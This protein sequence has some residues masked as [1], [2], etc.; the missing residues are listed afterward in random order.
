[1]STQ[2]AVDL[3][4]KTQ[5]LGKLKGLT[6]ET[7]KFQ[8]AAKKAQGSS[9]KLGR[10]LG[11]VGAKAGQA[12]N[13]ITKTGRAAKGAAKSIGGLRSALL[14][15][16]VGFAV[17]KAFGDASALES[18]ET[19]INSLTKAY[20]K[21]DGVQA[22]AAKSAEKFRLTQTEAL[23]AYADLGSRLGGTNTSLADLANI[24]DGFNTLL[25]N[26]KVEAQ[27]AAAA[28]LQLGQALGEGVLRAEE[29][30]SLIATTPQLLDEV[31]RVMKVP[32]AGLKA[33]AGEGKISSEALIQALANIK[34]KGADQ[35]E[36]S[37][38]GA[39]GTSKD[40]NKALSEFSVVIGT[41]LLPAIVPLLQ[42]ATELLKAFG[43]LPAPIKTASVAIAGTAVAA[44]LLAPAF[45]TAAAA[46]KGLVGVSAALIAAL[47]TQTALMVAFGPKIYAT[48]AAKGVL[49]AATGVLTKALGLLKVA[50][51][52]LPWAAFIAAAVAAANATYQ[53][54]AA[55]VDF[56]R[57]L[58]EAPLSEVEKKIEEL[59]KDLITAE[60]KTVAWYESLLDFIIGA[61]GASTAVD[62]LS[63]SI[64]RLNQRKIQLTDLRP[65]QGA[66]LDMDQIK[67]LSQTYEAPK[68][69]APKITAPSGGG[70]RGAA[71]RESEIP[72]LTRQI[73]LSD[74][75]LLIDKDRLEA[76]FQGNTQEIQR[77]ENLRVRTELEGKI[78]DIEAEKIPQAEQKLKI[79]LAENEAAL[80]G[81]DLKYAGLEADKQR[82]EA[83]EG[84]LTGFDREIELSNTK[85]DLAKG[86]LGIEHDII[87]MRKSGLLVGDE[88]IQQYR[89]RAKAALEASGAGKGKIQKKIEEYQEQLA[90]T[91]GMIVSLAGTVE[92][93]IGS[94]MSN[95][96]TGLIDGTTTAQ[97]AFSSMF[98][99]IGKAFID[100]ATQMIAKALI[101][102]ALGIL[103]G[104]GSSGGG[105]GSF[106]GGAPL[107]DLS[108]SMPWSSWAGGGYT[109]DGARSGGV[110]GQGGFPAILHPQET[111]IDHSASSAALARYS[112]NNHASSGAGGASG[113][114]EGTGG[115]G[116]F[117]PVINVS[118]GPTMQ[119]EG[120]NHVSQSDFQAGLAQAAKQGGE[121]G[122]QRALRK[123]RSS[124]A[125]R[126]RIG[127]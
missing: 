22:I 7:N 2:Y 77:L 95:A 114:S 37:L 78:A 38:A 107:G 48:A 46:I 127:M 33:L 84:M 13:G 11:G 92:S 120:S 50:M 45:G 4:L 56:N 113:E 47:K 99:N 104:G 3:V 102:K 28:Q 108:G 57:V 19:R 101:M 88:E 26:N 93:E 15:L 94:A 66:D 52:A 124:P 117:N 29:Y 18:A 9:D 64:D 112:P 100:M 17:K 75:L 12:A 98:K 106:G 121:Q 59:N 72:A 110:D 5:G 125:A 16:G 63:A 20:S 35:L 83:F 65:D 60:N 43:E 21:F 55:W 51:L 86:L 105:L 122:E 80:A 115:G 79:Q 116:A 103:M 14:G 53:A 44:A 109:G 69:T 23:A 24:Y 27:Q 42:A 71:P 118:T 90:D 58:S 67:K 91:E 41:E 74:K 34:T 119:F 87:D 40:F 111:V 81:L 126:R 70:G 31:A 49:A 62:G 96:I 82:E 61:D 89:D 25:I 54:F 6:G 76:Q 32:R 39:Y 8:S 73:E 123:L 97:E 30:N 1:M 85:G 10:A 36:E 68:I